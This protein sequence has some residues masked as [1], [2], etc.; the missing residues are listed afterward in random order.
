M[1]AKDNTPGMPSSPATPAVAA[2]IGTCSPMLLPNTLRKNSKIAPIS[3]FTIKLPKRRKG[4]NDAP[5]DNSKTIKMTMTGITMIGS[6]KKIP[7]RYS[8]LVQAMPQI[9]F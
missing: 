1:A 9:L 2:L 5:N 3:T 7:L 4:L 6:N 8:S